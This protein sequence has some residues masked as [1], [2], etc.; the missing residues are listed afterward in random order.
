MNDVFIVCMYM[1]EI[2]GRGVSEKEISSV[3]GREGGCGGEEI[4]Q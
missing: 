3:E 4:H 2:S 1:L